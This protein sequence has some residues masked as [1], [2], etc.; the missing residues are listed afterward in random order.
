MIEALEHRSHGRADVG[1]ITDP[2]DPL[3]D[4]AVEVDGHPERVTVQAGTLVTLW[5]LG[6]T[7]G[8][9][10][11]KFLEDLHF[12]PLAMKPVATTTAD[13]GMRSP[14]RTCRQRQD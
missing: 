11:P 13:Y 10:K 4:R 8:S 5:H 9:F 7:M 3:V 12:A 1:E 6:Q 14:T 2:P